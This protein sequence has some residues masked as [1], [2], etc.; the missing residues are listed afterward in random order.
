MELAEEEQEAI[1]P[2]EYYADEDSAGNTPSRAA[3]S[4]QLA[5]VR[6]KL[7][8]K[9][10][11]LEKSKEQTLAMRKKL[12][13]AIRKGKA[14]ESEKNEQVAEITSLKEKLKALSEQKS[15]GGGGDREREREEEAGGERVAELEEQV[16]AAEERERSWKQKAE[17][18]LAQVTQL[19]MEAE[20]LQAKAKAKN[21]G[22]AGQGGGG[23]AGSDDLRGEVSKL[24]KEKR[25]LEQKMKLEAAVK[26]GAIKEYS[27]K[28]EAKE[29]EML[30]LKQEMSTLQSAVRSAAERVADATAAESRASEEQEN[31]KGQVKSLQRRVAELEGQLNV[32][33][34]HE[35]DKQRILNETLNLRTE[36]DELE[37][38]KMRLES[39]NKTKQE[40]L[41]QVE[42]SLKSVQDECVR[43]A[44][45]AEQTKAEA[46]QELEEME[47]EMSELRDRSSAEVKS[48]LE[49]E[50]LATER[51]E[52]A[53]ES[54][55]E[56]TQSLQAYRLD[57]EDRKKKFSR[58][59]GQY[60]SELQQANTEIERLKE[61][62][63]EQQK[64]VEEYSSM[65]AENVGNGVEEETSLNED[66]LRSAL[67]AATEPL[68]EKIE[69]YRL[70]AEETEKQL[71]DSR[72]KIMELTASLAQ[73]EISASGHMKVEES[74]GIYKDE[75]D[76]AK[77]RERALQQQV[78]DL[79]YERDTLK[80]ANE[81]IIAGDSVASSSEIKLMRE[82]LEEAQ[83]LKIQAEDATR[84]VKK[85]QKE[86]KDLRW[87][88]AMTSTDESIKVDIPKHLV[89]GSKHLPQPTG[90]LAFVVK[91][92]K[93]ILIFYLLLLHFLVYFA[94][95]H[96]SNK[97]VVHHTTHPRH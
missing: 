42:E 68:S 83:M 60:S 59:Q 14:I 4:S 43:L 53:A 34:E 57:E 15:V 82:Q 1:A 20:T 3:E 46:K 55:R 19:E 48:A 93:Q 62:L 11:E 63:K 89:D 56:M 87:Q 33:G 28:L 88:I 39:D 36:R 13:N 21:V 71:K 8:T 50:T 44:E 29:A 80:R 76:Q 5:R 79:V 61:Q 31:Q 70:K 6:S 24:N 27:D 81:E 85:L 91:H 22:E 78:D 92:R 58:L 52:K 30:S 74:V 72:Q 54:M 96:H 69:E 77:T 9:E 35:E 7:K 84:K 94:L 86:N 16:A 49:K 40:L 51:E 18:S 37:N 66:E 97:K 41:F 26:E 95:T 75:V 2:G 32:A 67:L 10:E 12:H 17:A 64:V 73:M 65:K 38:E 45:V 47:L 90:P 23:G 25:S